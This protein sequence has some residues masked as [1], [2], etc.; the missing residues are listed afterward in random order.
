MF[1]ISYYVN[2]LNLRNLKVKRDSVNFSCPYCG[3][4]EHNK[5]K[6]RGYIFKYK[7]SMIYK[8][9]NCGISKNFK[10]FLKDQN[11]VVFEEYLKD[12][13]KYKYSNPKKE[14][15]IIQEADLDLNNPLNNFDKISQLDENHIAKLYLKERKIPEKYFDILYF[16]PNFK[17]YINSVDSFRFKKLQDTDKR[18]IIPSF[19]IKGELI[20]L[21]GRSIENDYLRYVT[22]KIKKNY[23]KIYGLDRLEKNKPVYVTEGPIDSLFIDNCLAVAGSDLALD[24]LLPLEPILIYDNE[25]R[26]EIIVKKINNAIDKG[27]KVVIHDT[28]NDKKD[29]NDM[30][31][32]GINPM[33]YISK[34]QFKGLNAKL[35][36]SN[37][38]KISK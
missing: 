4:S 19:N 13:L 9:H 1:E 6:S 14:S 23:P 29:I 38:S 30:V 31:L 8:C 2:Q 33:E 37:W 25:P 10:N 20:F 35:E 21:Q 28:K 32:D 24:C 18:I 5:S 26:N 27:F 17:K 22:L 11:Y 34:R 16:T 7:G 15:V 3:D 12:N 36:L